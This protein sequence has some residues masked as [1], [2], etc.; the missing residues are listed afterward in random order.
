MSDS[1]GYRNTEWVDRRVPGLPRVYA[2]SAL[3]LYRVY[4]MSTPC[5]HSV[6]TLSTQSLPCAYP[7]STPCL[8]SVYT[9]TTLCLHPVHPEFTLRLRT[10]VHRGCFFGRRSPCAA[11]TA[12]HPGWD[13]LMTRLGVLHGN[14]GRFFFSSHLS[15]Y[16]MTCVC[17][18]GLMGT[19]FRLQGRRENGF[20]LG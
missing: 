10:A 17:Q 2:E 11:C 4:T 3:C 19:Y 6:Y 5:L 7:V 20:G 14:V 13:H 9:V 12:G 1:A 16:P 18:W 8:P 15:I